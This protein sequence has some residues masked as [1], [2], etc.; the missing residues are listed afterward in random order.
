[1]A[2][3]P[4]TP[5]RLASTS[6]IRSLAL[7]RHRSQPTHGRPLHFVAMFRCAQYGIAFL[8]ITMASPTQ[9]SDTIRLFPTDVSRFTFHEEL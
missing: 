3:P 5:P 6:A 2:A 7:L 9:Q 4:S 1:M 8:L